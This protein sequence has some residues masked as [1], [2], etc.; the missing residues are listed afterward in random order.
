MLTYTGI[1]VAREFGAPSIRDIAV[2]SMRIARFSGAG[3]I[4]W[5]IGMHMLLVADLVPPELECHGLLHDAAEVSVADVPKPMKTADL[6]ELENAVLYRIYRLLG[7]PQPT[8]GQRTEI[9]KADFRA[10]LAEGALGCSGRG[11]SDT[12]TGFYRDNKAEEILL[13]YLKTFK[14]QEAIDPDGQWAWR[15]EHRLRAAL[16]RAQ[17]SVSYAVEAA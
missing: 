14:P 2:Q 11:F 3:N 13:Q 4:W 6:R 9:K 5:P 16:R 1:H 15:Y 7:A 8:A 17:S 12:Q 10:A